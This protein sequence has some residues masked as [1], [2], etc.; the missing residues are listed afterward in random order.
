MSLGGGVGGVKVMRAAQS[1]LGLATYSKY[2]IL[3][4]LFLLFFYVMNYYH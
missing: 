1:T 3:F 4:S 2:V